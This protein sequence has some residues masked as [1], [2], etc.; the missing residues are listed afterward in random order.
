MVHT[1]GIDHGKTCFEFI[2]VVA[3]VETRETFERSRLGASAANGGKFQESAA[4]GKEGDGWDLVVPYCTVGYRSG[5]YAK[6]LLD[7]G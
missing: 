5:Q 6:K 7:L 4:G 3:R 1:Q 2:G